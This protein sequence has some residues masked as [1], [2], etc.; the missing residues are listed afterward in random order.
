M[1]DVVVARVA[2]PALAGRQASARAVAS[3]ALVE[4]RRLIVHPAYL[5][6]I[7]LLVLTAGID[8]VNSTALTRGSIASLLE[9]LLLWVPLVSVFP[10]NLVASSARRAN[11]EETLDAAPLP[12]RARTL[13]LCLAALGPAALS[14]GGVFAYWWVAYRAGPVLEGAMPMEAIASV[15]LLFV[16]AGALGVATTRWLPVPGATLAV[17]IGLVAW[18]VTFGSAPIGAWFCPWVVAFAEPD[19]PLAAGGSHL[20]HAVYLLGLSGLAAVAALLRHPGGR[21]SLMAAGALVA[22]L[23]ALAGWAQLP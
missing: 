17:V 16:G 3:L 18:T 22:V 11:A 14:S 10:A 1:T 13:A 12:A 5:A 8:A 21:R 6:L 2:I 7:G 20:W 23:T 9:L 19:N 15:P 4:A